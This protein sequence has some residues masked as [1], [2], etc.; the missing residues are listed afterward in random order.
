M[1]HASPDPDAEAVAAVLDALGHGLVDPADA[2]AL[3]PHLR[4]EGG[5]QLAALLR[6]HGVAPADV[7]SA[8]DLLYGYARQ[9]ADRLG[10]PGFADLMRTAIHQPDFAPPPALRL[11]LDEAVR[12]VRSGDDWAALLTLLRRTATVMTLAAGSGRIP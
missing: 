4:G 7:L 9:Q 8:A 1:T 6:T 12:L 2:S 5:V 11:V 10:W 3:H